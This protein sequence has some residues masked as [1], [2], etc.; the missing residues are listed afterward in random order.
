MQ[1]P[2]L[3]GIG[4]RQSEFV[5]CAPLNLEPLAIDSKISKGQLLAGAGV[6]SRGTG[7][8]IDRGGINWNGVNYRV[9]GTKLVRVNQDFSVDTLGDVGSGG[10]VNLDYSFDRLGINSGTSLYYW[11]GSNLVQVTDSDLGDVIDVMWVDGYF[12]TTDGNS[13]PVTE[14]ADPTS[15]I[16]LKYGSAEQDPDPVTGLM[17]NR[18]TDEPLVIGRYTIQPLQNVGGNGFP[19]QAVVGGTIPVGCVSAAAKA[20]VL[21]GFAFVGSARDESLGV[22]IFNGQAPTKISTREVDDA[23]AAEVDET[24][25]QVECR[26]YRD[27]QRVYVHL[28]NE[29]WVYLLKLSEK[30]EEPIWYRVQ[31]GIGGKYRPRHAVACYGK[32]ICGDA[33]S[34]AIGELSETVD[35]HFGTETQWQFDPGLI[36]NGGKGGI[37]NSLE[38]IGLPGRASSPGSIFLSMTKDGEAYGEEFPLT[39]SPGERRKR[40][41]WRKHRKF[42]PY[43]GLRF[44]GIGTLPGFAALEAEITGLAV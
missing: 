16:P 14:L 31:S 25:I 35:T 4:T 34:S 39:I 18:Q 43:L 37:V 21:S 8:G 15:V 7:P 22:H 2:L 28:E 10:P 13:V 38:L 20:Y 23:L 3:S 27:E 5:T 9:M 33:T 44:R 24:A 17:K 11:D 12:M 42:R 6:V 41:I 32:L 19:F 29:S 1:V 40:I 30:A 26:S 36:Y